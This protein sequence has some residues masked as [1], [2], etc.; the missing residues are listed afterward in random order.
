MTEYQFDK[1]VAALESGD[2]KQCRQRLHEG[3]AYCCLGV[4]QKVNH[5]NNLQ[6]AGG[7][8]PSE[9]GDM[10]GRDERVFVRANDTYM[11][12]FAEIAKLA[13]DMKQVL[14]APGGDHVRTS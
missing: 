14:L 12:S 8:Y 6:G 1:W 7:Y 2:Y 5:P 4:Y 11:Q 10:S 3:D 9:V 13:R